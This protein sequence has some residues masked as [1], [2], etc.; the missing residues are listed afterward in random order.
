[1]KDRKMTKAPSG[2]GS[3]PGS[4]ARQRSIYRVTIGGSIINM[5]LL[6]FKFAAGILGNSAAMIADT[7]HSLTD[8][9]T[10]IVVLVFVRLGN[11]P[12]DKDHDYGHGKYETLAT[13]VIGIALLGVGAMIC[14]N[15][16]MKTWQAIQ[17]LPLRQ[18]G[19][20][21]LAA[22]LLSIILKEWA[23]Q[24]TY[25]TGRRV[26]SEATIANAWHHRSDA[27]SSV[28]TALGVGGAI[29]LGERW[30]VLDPIAAIIVS[31]FIIRT[32]Y[33]LVHQAIGELLEKSLP[34]DTEDEIMQ[35]A[36]GEEGVSGIHN[37]R[38]RSL[39]NHIA[40]EMHI[41][42]AGETT[43]YAAHEHASRI[44]RRLKERFGEG[45]HIALHVEP[46]KVNGEYIRPE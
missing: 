4:D 33:R 46:L 39:G 8:F 12:K 24:F 38:T 16:V 45:T 14:Y 27:L 41:R 7:V 30:A 5:V 11:R 2:N 35:I 26:H 40:I 10:D 22:A 34:D 32:A 20:I 25:R 42:M 9:M 1:M 6:V 36:A 29:V 19:V 17:G 37:L 18:P 21:A 43:L 15:G 23:Y 3:E 13:A 28:G 31:V 44:E